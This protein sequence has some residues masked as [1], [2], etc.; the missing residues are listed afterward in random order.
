[1]WLVPHAQPPLLVTV[2]RTYWYKKK[3]DLGLAAPP[4]LCKIFIERSIERHIVRYWLKS[5]LRFFRNNSDIFGP[6]PILAVA[7]AVARD[8]HQPLSP[9]R[10]ASWLLFSAFGVDIALV[11]P[12]DVPLG[13][14]HQV[15]SV[16]LLISLASCSSAKNE[17]ALHAKFC[18]SVTYL[19][20]KHSLKLESQDSLPITMPFTAS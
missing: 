5:E 10:T 8:A 9:V 11:Q 15:Q 7:T 20:P 16:D 19:R 3:V 14:R 17:N 13:R 4:S 2:C 1:M 6:G 12:S 18:I